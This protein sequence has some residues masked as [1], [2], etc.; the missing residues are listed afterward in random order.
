M[1]GLIFAGLSAFLMSTSAIAASQ[2]TFATTAQVRLNET[3]SSKIEKAPTSN[4]TTTLQILPNALVNL[5][6]QGR[7]SNQGIPG[8]AGLLNAYASGRVRATNL[9]Q[10]AID[11]GRLPAE[12]LSNSNY[13]RNVESRLASLSKV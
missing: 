8:H 3:S 9:I 10:A 4:S 7:F 2:P 12:T 1:K 5:A 13:V 6:Y 11:T